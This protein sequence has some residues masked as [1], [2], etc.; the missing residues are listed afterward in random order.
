MCSESPDYW[1][2][3]K[4]KRRTV[5]EYCVPDIPTITRGIDAD[6]PLLARSV[7]ERHL[8]LTEPTNQRFLEDPDGLDQHQTQWH[9]W[10][11]ITHTRVFLHALDTQVPAYLETW[12]LWTEVRRCL[13]QPID[14]ASRW[15]LLHISVLLHDIGKFAARRVGRGRFHFAGHER[16]SG[17]II[18]SDLGLK[19]R[20]LSAAQ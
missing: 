17:A 14:G 7:I 9:Q 6:L 5:P 4:M 12:E 16:L 18:R 1:T 15:D 11:I 10:G 2:R 8:D 13:C 20:G 19:K 3:S